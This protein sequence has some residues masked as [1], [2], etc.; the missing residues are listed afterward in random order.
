MTPEPTA[1]AGGVRFGRGV[2]I[3][4]VRDLATS[5]DHYVRVLGFALDWDYRGIFASVSRGG[6]RLFLCESD[7]GRP[8]T[9][10]WIGVNDASE[11]HE[12]YRAAGAT[13]RHP[14]TNYSW[15]CEMQ[16]EDPDSNVLRLGSDPI[17]GEPEGAWLDMHG[18]IWGPRVDGSPDPGSAD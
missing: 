9:W 18:R 3:F 7:Q 17:V 5:V 12:E 13:I 11:L 1:D 15:A 10:A 4:P 8:G 6:F 14:P 2:P 16:V